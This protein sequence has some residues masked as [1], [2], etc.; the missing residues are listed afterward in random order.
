MNDLECKIFR[1]EGRGCGN[2]SPD[3]AFPQEHRGPAFKT[4]FSLLNRALRTRSFNPVRELCL[5][6]LLSEYGHTY[7]PEERALS[8]LSFLRTLAL[9]SSVYVYVS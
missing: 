9:K 2:V 6:V 4:R 7:S 5:S 3:R 1:P 8:L